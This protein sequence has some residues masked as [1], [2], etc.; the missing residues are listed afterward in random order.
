MSVA[1]RL[2]PSPAR[3]LLR[4]SWDSALSSALSVA[5]RGPG[6]HCPVCGGDFRVFRA[7]RGRQVAMCPGCR[8]L[9]RHRA[10][11]LIWRSQTNLFDEPL[12]VLH[13]APEPG[14]ETL[15]RAA[16]N[17]DYVTADIEPGVA[18][19]VID[20]TGIDAPDGAFDV[21][22]CSHVLEHIPDDAR[23][24]REIRRVLSPTGWA[25]L[26][27]PTDPGR[28]E[29]YEDPSIVTPEGR[30][31]AF[32]QADHVRWYTGAAFEERLRLAGF[33]VRR[34]QVDDAETRFRCVTE[35]FDSPDYATICTV[36]DEAIR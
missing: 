9:E 23:A 34:V 28:Q 13:F 2:V 3:M 21:V 14:L 6:L 15:L 18:D 10:A 17:L 1:Q 20:I 16:P 4:T 26:V 36:V 11:L 29:V 24:M 35:R 22:L 33:A 30:L 7:F 5:L 31:A 25:F 32:G 8:S 27:V 12:R 19:R